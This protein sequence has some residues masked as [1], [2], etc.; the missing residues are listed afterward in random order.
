M[1]WGKATVLILIVFVLFIGS[2]SFYMFISPKDEYDHQ[3]YEDG[4]NFDHDYNREAQVTKDHAQP[5]IKITADSILITFPQAVAGNL[6]LM[7]PSSDAPDKNYQLAGNVTAIPIAQMVKG[8]WQLIFDWQ[9]NH[10][11]YLYHQEI[12]IK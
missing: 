3:Y 7:R 2:M 12:Y 5:E 1:N 8:K 11:A 4:I 10:K 6:K 9:S